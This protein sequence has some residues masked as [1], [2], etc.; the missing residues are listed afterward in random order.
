MAI[1]GAWALLTLVSASS[2]YLDG[3]VRPELSWFQTVL[4][5]GSI[6]VLWVVVAPVIIWLARRFPID[7]GRWPRA[8]AVHLGS[9]LLWT[10][11]YFPLTLVVI[12]TWGEQPLFPDFLAGLKG[13]GYRALHEAF[14]YWVI[15]VAAYA[16]WHFEGRRSEQKRGAELAVRNAEIREELIRSELRTLRDQLHPHFLFNTLNSIAGLIR[17]DDRDTALQ[18]LS[19][20]SDLLR[21]TLET[22]RTELVPLAKEIEFIERYLAIQQVRFRDRLQVAV[23]VA[24]GCEAFQLPGMILQPLV[25]N[26]VHHGVD[27]NRQS[28]RVELRARQN[29]DRLSIT[30]TNTTGGESKDHSGFGIGLKNVRKRL[31]HIYGEDF[32]LDLGSAANELMTVTLTIPPADGAKAVPAR[33]E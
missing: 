24:D 29:D 18:V 1:L 7:E 2:Y 27:N 17:T 33:M 22:E 30:I 11:L 28:N 16:Y 23:G 31:Q 10:L 13:Y 19:R 5:F 32:L 25:E 21:Y 8:L 6:W 3:A 26:A 12:R 9:S 14:I 4:Q 15:A 20:L